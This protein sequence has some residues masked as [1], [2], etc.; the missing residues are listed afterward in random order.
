[1]KDKRNASGLDPHDNSGFDFSEMSA[2]VCLAILLR[3][4]NKPEEII[5]GLRQCKDRVARLLTALLDEDGLNGW[6]L[7]IISTKGRRRRFDWRDYYPQRFKPTVEHRYAVLRADGMKAIS[8]WDVVAKEF[9]IT[10]GAVRERVHRERAAA[11]KGLKIIAK[12]LGITPDQV[13][14]LHRIP[15]EKQLGGMTDNDLRQAV[16]ELDKERKLL[17]RNSAAHRKRSR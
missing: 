3:I 14:L 13:P 11:K 1:M 4:A 7:K 9:N 8:A 15:L 6:R 10:P 5:A 12:K 16:A 2:L 17:Q